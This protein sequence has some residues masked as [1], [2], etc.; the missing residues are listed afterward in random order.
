[1]AVRFIVDAHEVRG[2]KDLMS[3]DILDGFDAAK[4]EIASG[5]YEIVGMP[6]LRVRIEQRQNSGT[7]H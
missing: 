4:I 6:E 1:M 7:A 5:T 3:R 2:V